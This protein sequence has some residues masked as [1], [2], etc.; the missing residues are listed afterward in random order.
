MTA[1]C[2][3]LAQDCRVENE[4]VKKAVQNLEFEIVKNRFR[5]AEFNQ[6]QGMIRDLEFCDADTFPLLYAF[7][8]ENIS[9]Q[10]ELC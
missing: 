10:D 6:T 2:F 9:A 8:K 7:K 5:V 3:K 4:E 1:N